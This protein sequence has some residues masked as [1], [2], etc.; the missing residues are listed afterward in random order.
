MPPNGVIKNT[1]TV[2]QNDVTPSRNGRMRQAV[3]EPGLRRVLHPRAH[4]RDE[5]AGEEQAVVAMAKD[6]EQARAARMRRARRVP[7]R[8]AAR[9]AACR[10]CCPV[11]RSW[12]T[13][14]A[15]QHP[16]LHAPV[17]VTAIVFAGNVHVQ[18]RG[19]LQAVPAQVSCPAQSHRHGA[20]DA[21]EIAGPN[22]ER[23]SC[24]ILSGARRRRRRSDSHGRNR[25]GTQVG[26]QRRQRAALSRRRIAQGLGEGRAR[27]EGGRRPHHAAAL[28]SGRGAPSRHRPLSRSAEHE[29]VGSRARRTRRSPSR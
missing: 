11:R 5:L 3:D 10:R 1:G 25:A 26:D 24:R 29:P 15:C 27:S 22:P 21:V 8:P 14:D 9:P 4:Q 18:Y 28:A 2:E 6:L 7:V 19:T 23:P 12:P 20:H 13:I 17:A 16:A